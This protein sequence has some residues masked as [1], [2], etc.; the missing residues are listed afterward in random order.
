MVN[1]GI[2]KTAENSTSRHQHHAHKGNN[3]IC[4]A[5][6]ISSVKYN[7]GWAYNPKYH[8]PFKPTREF[9]PVFQYPPSLTQRIDK[10]SDHHQTTHQT[11]VITNVIASLVKMVP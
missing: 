9:P 2:E 7:D 10:Q 8:V 6:R 4:R 3:R 11:K 1:F 5:K